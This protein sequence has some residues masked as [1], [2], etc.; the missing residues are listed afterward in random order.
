[1]HLLTL[2]RIDRASS[3]PTVLYCQLDL[4][5]MNMTLNRIQKNIDEDKTVT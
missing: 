3:L 5:S 4:C 2:D 1:M